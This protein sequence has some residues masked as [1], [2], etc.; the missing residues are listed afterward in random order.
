[1]AK[2]NKLFF[3]T[4][5]SAKFKDLAQDDNSVFGKVIEINLEDNSFRI[6]SKGHRNPQGL[7][8][9]KDNYL[10]AT[11]HGPYGGD[12]VNNIIGLSSTAGGGGFSPMTYDSRIKDAP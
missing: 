3:T 1:M 5:A 7:M 10:I 4:S 2:N 11:E 8:V 6:F 12:E 9:T